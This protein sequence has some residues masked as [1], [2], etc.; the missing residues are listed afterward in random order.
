MQYKEGDKV[1]LVKQEVV[2]TATIL[3]GTYGMHQYFGKWVTIKEVNEHS[4][5]IEETGD[6][7]YQ[8][9]Y[10]WIVANESIGYHIEMLREKVIQNIRP[11]FWNDDWGWETDD[12]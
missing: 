5:S 9:Q 11:D 2:S 1:L 7:N 8:W 10:E 3:M 12:L 4:F 6:L